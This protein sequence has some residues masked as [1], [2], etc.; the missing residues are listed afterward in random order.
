MVDGVSKGS[1][2]AYKFKNVKASH[3]I[4]GD[5]R[6]QDHGLGS[7]AT[8]TRT[9]CI[10]A[11]LAYPKW[12]G[13]KHVVI[14]SGDTRD[15]FEAATAPGLSGAYNAPLLTNPRS[16][17]RKDVRAA[18]IAMPNGLKVH[19][20]GKGINAATKKQLQ[21]RAGSLVGGSRVRQRQ[22]LDSGFGCP[23]DEDGPRLAVPDCDPH[24]CRIGKQARAGLSGRRGRIGK[25]ALPASV[26]EDDLCSFGDDQDAGRSRSDEAL[27]RGREARCEPGGADASWACRRSTASVGVTLGLHGCSV[28]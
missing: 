7:R 5:L 11:K 20:V 3:T 23:E 9:R 22:L 27:H 8:R 15:L 1:I 16:G 18:L 28:R 13:V 4:A 6:A 21:K 2:K 19:I 14:T 10:A 17:L 26:R 25:E 24:R 12:T